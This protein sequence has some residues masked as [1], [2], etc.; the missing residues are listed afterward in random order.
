MEIKAETTFSNPF[1]LCNEPNVSFLFC[2]DL[3]RLSYTNDD[4]DDDD[5]DEEEE[6]SH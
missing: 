6:R 3:F 1:F 5:E 2:S 4:D